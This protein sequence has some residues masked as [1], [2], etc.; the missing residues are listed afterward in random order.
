MYATVMSYPKLPILEL[1]ST[2]YY[3]AVGTA[4]PFAVI[5][6]SNVLIIISLRKAAKERKKL[7][8]TQNVRFEKDT[9]YLTRMLIFVSLA[10]IVLSLPFRLYHLL[11]RIPS[12]TYDL[13]DIYWKRRYVMQ[14]WFLGLVWMLNY[15]VNFYL[16]CV[17]GG[18][19]YRLEA[20]SVVQE[21]FCWTVCGSSTFV[22]P[23]HEY[24][25]ARP[26]SLVSG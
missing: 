20:K 5:F 4:L 22:E 3:V 17:G 21:L 25:N 18:R 9:Q 23:E 19:K 10:Y 6:T 26:R 14:S 16:Y 12:L 24:C 2:G 11:M 15:S 1:I 8:T 7:E 13:S